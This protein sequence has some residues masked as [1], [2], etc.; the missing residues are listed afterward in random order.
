MYMDRMPYHDCEWLI[1]EQW[2]EP[3]Q[4]DQCD[5]TFVE[6]SARQWHLYK[7]HGIDEPLDSLPGNA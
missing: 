6:W 2:Q 5:E 7:I 4:C 3:I 1:C